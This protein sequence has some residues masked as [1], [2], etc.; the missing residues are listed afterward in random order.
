LSYGN[1]GLSLDKNISLHE[2]QEI[3][4]LFLQIGVESTL[5]RG[6]PLQHPAERVRSECE[7]KVDDGFKVR[8]LKLRH[9]PDLGSPADSLGSSSDILR[10]YEGF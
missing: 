1:F 3:E 5:N 10:L 2:T 7:E 8:T 4:M 9:K 6:P